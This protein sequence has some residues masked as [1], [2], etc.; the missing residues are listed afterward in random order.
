MELQPGTKADNT[1]KQG[2]LIAAS[3]R[4]VCFCILSGLAIMIIAGVVLLPD[5][6]RLIQLRYER[7]CLAAKNA[8]DKSLAL[9]YERLADDIPTDPILAKRLA[10]RQFGVMPR[11][12]WVVS[13]GSSQTL[14]LVTAARHSRP[15]KPDGWTIHTA[16]KLQN[17]TTRTA[18]LLTAIILI[19]AAIV[20]SAPSQKK[21]TDIAT[22]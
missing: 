18:L 13:S 14:P 10:M 9:A 1:R 8:D 17:P 4:M 6:A 21:S 3:G 12:E 7:D 2:G 11:D 22:S 19:L 16:K 5:H 15:A 20:L